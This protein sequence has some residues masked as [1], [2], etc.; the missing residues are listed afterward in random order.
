MSRFVE[1]QRF[2]GLM[3]PEAS[4]FDPRKMVPDPQKWMANT[5]QPAPPDSPLH[6]PTTGQDLVGVAIAVAGWLLWTFARRAGHEDAL[7]RRD[8]EE[9]QDGWKSLLADARQASTDKDRMIAARD[10]QI[11]R[12]TTALIEQSSMARDVA[13]LKNRNASIGAEKERLAELLRTAQRRLDEHMALLKA[14]TGGVGGN[15]LPVS[16]DPLGMPVHV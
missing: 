14:S 3:I 5:A 6:L 9:R 15:F 7:R 16:I 11:E 10:S 1:D 12:L 8:S 4:D 13:E 2:P